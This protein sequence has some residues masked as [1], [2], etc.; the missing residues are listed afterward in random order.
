VTLALADAFPGVAVIVHYSR[1]P[2]HD[3]VWSGD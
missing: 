3:Q 2:L 1:L